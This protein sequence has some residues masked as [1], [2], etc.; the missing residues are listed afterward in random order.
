MKKKLPLQSKVQHK[1]LMRIVLRTPELISLS[2]IKMSVTASTQN[3]VVEKVRFVAHTLGPVAPGAQ[4]SQNHW[5]VYLL[6]KGGGSV[7]LNMATN[8]RAGD[9][10]GVFT[11]TR[12]A[13]AL[14]TSAV[15]HFDFAVAKDVTV[16]RILRLIGEKRR[17]RYRMTP[18]GVGCRHWMYVF[19][20][21]SIHPGAALMLTTS[22]RLTIGSDMAGAALFA[23]SN[24]VNLLS[25]HLQY[26]YSR[27][28]E[29]VA[30]EIKKGTFF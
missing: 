29:P 1:K 22:T 15:R 17:Q 18:T 8:D 6:V 7:R 27:N 30:L 3:L 2:I 11:V 24:A 23:E 28:R 25:Q 19:R 9:D 5:S 13:Y 21:L 20:L 12:H 4:L 26:N 16:G 14:T 10:N